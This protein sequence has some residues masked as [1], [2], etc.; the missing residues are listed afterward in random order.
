MTE[1]NL[2]KPGEPFSN[3]LMVKSKRAGM[4]MKLTLKTKGVLLF[5]LAQ[6]FFAAFSLFLFTR[7]D[8]LVHTDLYTHGLQFSIG[9]ADTYWTFLR[10]TLTFLLLTILVTCGAMVF[11][12]LRARTQQRSWV[13]PNF[14][15]V[16]GIILISGTLFCYTRLDTII[17]TDLYTY[18]LQ[19]SQDWAMPYW[20][21]ANFVLGLLGFS[22][23]TSILSITI[24][25][26]TS[27]VEADPKHVLRALLVPV[28]V[29]ALAL[30]IQFDST[31]LALVGLGLTFWGIIF[32]YISSDE[33][34]KSVLLDATTLPSLITL[35]KVMDELDFK[36]RA[37][38]LP[39]KYLTDPNENKVY[40]SK[41]KN[42]GIPLPD[43][44]QTHE[45]QL[46]TKGTPGLLLTPPGD[47]LTK[48]FENTLNTNFTG[49][50]LKTLQQ[51]LPKLIIEDLELAQSF[52][53]HIEH[54][55]VSVKMENSIY[56]ALC[57]ATANLN[58]SFLGCPLSSA[59]ACALAKTT[60]DP[61]II[62]NHQVQDNHIELE[63]RVLREAQSG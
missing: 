31:I 33:Y 14:L 30:S 54:N 2:Y 7:I 61:I 15:L 62:E 21:Y 51:N 19:F 39:P 13:A 44:I 25:S 59:L 16:L 56:E 18:G 22:I 60:G 11:I 47:E 46:F 12:L 26:Y 34:V 23:V 20:T 57:K 28:G 24:L 63:Y 32:F 55:T 9:W 48:L 10:L 4:I 42:L 3:Y 5:L 6:L 49:T 8:N 45:T 38:Y 1:I 50:D 40:I 37:V 53:M 43:Q 58:T 27:M 29:L 36:G 17:H 41:Q 52:D 35:N